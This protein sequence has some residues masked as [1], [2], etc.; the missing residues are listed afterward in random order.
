M[1]AGPPGAALGGGSGKWRQKQRAADAH[2]FRGAFYASGSWRRMLAGKR[3]GRV[4][5]RLTSANVTH[6]AAYADA[7]WD[8][9]CKC[10]SAFVC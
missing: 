9:A 8:E 6:P 4:S 7:L 2:D 1:R 5:E 10:V 3:G